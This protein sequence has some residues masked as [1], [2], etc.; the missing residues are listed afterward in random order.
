MYTTYVH[1]K[2]R[3]VL[4]RNAA[5]YVSDS[6]LE[7]SLQTFVPKMAYLRNAIFLKQWNRSSKGILIWKIFDLSLSLNGSL[8]GMEANQ[9]QARE[10]ASLGKLNKST[11]PDLL[12]FWWAQEFISRHF[13]WCLT[14]SARS[15]SSPICPETMTLFIEDSLRFCIYHFIFLSMFKLRDKFSSALYLKES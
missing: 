6:K 11:S 3:P 12:W 5:I 8:A 14:T 7:Y 15:L 4:L 9:S 10:Q 2:T 1:G 13:C